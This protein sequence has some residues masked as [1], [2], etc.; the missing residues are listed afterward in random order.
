LKKRIPFSN[1]LIFHGGF[2]KFSFQMST[3]QIRRGLRN[4]RTRAATIDS[5]AEKGDSA[6]D[7]VLPLLQD[8]NDGVRWSAIKILTEIGDERAIGPLIHLLEQSKNATDV[9]NALRAITGQELGD[10]PGEWR[11]WATGEAK[12]DDTAG[13]GGTLSDGDLIAAA[14]QDL[15]ATV[16][17]AEQ[18]YIV[19]V[20]LPDG[21][22]QQ[23][24]VYLSRVDPNGRPIVQ[25]CT[26]CGDADEEHYEAVLKLNMSIPYGAVGI[27]SL[28][29]SLCFAMVDSHLRE[30][31]HPESLAESIMSLARHGD[32]IEKSLSGDDQY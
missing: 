25:L 19:K 26:A 20:S 4:F 27:A 7:G 29:D 18:D 15:P 5:V 28:D 23:V 30:N 11:S 12:V 13:G 14:T 21:R 3:D 31:I 16:E 32:S 17:G 22:S 2:G 8:R 6:I 24:W 10:D 9:E 1:A